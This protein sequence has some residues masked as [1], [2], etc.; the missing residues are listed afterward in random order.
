MKILLVFTELN[1]KFGALR[2][3]HGLAFL[4]AV[5]KQNGYPDVSLS[6]FAETLDLNQWEKD[7][8]QIQP[9]LI[10]FYSTAEQFHFIKRLIEAVPKPIFTICGGPHPSCYPICLEGIP[11]LDAICVGEGEYPFWELVQALDEGRDYTQIK[12]LW[13]RRNG[14]II[15]NPTR[16]FIQ[17]LD[18]L[19]FEDREL[20]NTQEAIDQYGL[21]QLRVMTSRGCPF[22]CTYCSNKKLSKM[23]EG[24]YVR[25]RSASHILGELNDIQKKYK[26]EEIFFDDDIFMMNREIVEEFCE[27][28]PREIGKSFVFC[29]RVEACHQEILVK[30]K[31]AGGRRIDFGVESGHEEVRRS[32]LKRKMTNRQI[33]NA[34]QLAKSVGLQVKTLNMVGLPEETPEKFKETIKINQAI[35]PEVASLYVFY[36]YPGTELYDY[37]LEKGYL[38]PEESLPENYIS[39]RDSILELPYFPKNDI[40]RCYRWFAFRVFWRHSL[41][42]AVGYTLINSKHGEFFMAVTKKFRKILRKL[43]KG[44]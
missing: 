13:V 14:Q 39:R 35:K 7:L 25:Y 15:K 43:L 28:Y 24:R 21:S 29:G 44:F 19:P 6:Y 18:E 4:S 23:Q 30:L 34:T 20:F 42:K 11:R 36:P 8:K 38:H 31:T 33:I 26:F 41:I 37:C 2:S 9:D 17:N 3:Q 1:Q 40:N 10:G 5:L 16:P 12:N 27:R 22:S 32:I